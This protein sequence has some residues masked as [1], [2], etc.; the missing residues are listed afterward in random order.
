L[1]GAALYRDIIDDGRFRQAK[2]AVFLPASGRNL[3]LTDFTARIPIQA[4]FEFFPFSKRFFFTLGKYSTIKSGA[5]QAGKPAASGVVCRA[6]QLV[7]GR[8]GWSSI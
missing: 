5:K 3:F 8:S 4:D 6:K 7:A 1:S 2:A